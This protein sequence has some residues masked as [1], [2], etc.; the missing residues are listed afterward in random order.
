[1]SNTEENYAQSSTTIPSD[2]GKLIRKRRRKKKKMTRMAIGS[3]STMI[4]GH[5]GKLT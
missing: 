1:L 3:R 2:D 5:T 4:L